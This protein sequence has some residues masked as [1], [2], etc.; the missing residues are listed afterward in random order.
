MKIP[1]LKPLSRPRARCLRHRDPARRRKGS[2][3]SGA[4]GPLEPWRAAEVRCSPTGERPFSRALVRWASL[5][6]TLCAESP[7]GDSSRTMPAAPGHPRQRSVRRRGRSAGS[8]DCWRQLTHPQRSASRAAPARPSE[9]SRAPSRRSLVAL[10]QVDQART[11]SVKARQSHGRCA[12]SPSGTNEIA[13]RIPPPSLTAR[14][15]SPSH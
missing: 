7:R 4:L 11:A 12:R 8:P 10:V 5:P 15:T 1:L 9:S 6:E 3:R 13:A 2:S 14:V